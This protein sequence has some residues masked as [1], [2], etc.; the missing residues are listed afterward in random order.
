MARAS[1]NW[2]RYL[3]LMVCLFLL[4]WIYGY[5]DILPLRP[6]SIHQWRQADCLSL[7]DN[8]YKGK[9]GLFQPSLH[10]LFSDQETSGKSAG[11]FPLL[12][13]L[14][15]IL[16]K[17]FGKHE[18]IF[19]LVVMAFSF[20]GMIA[21]YK[22]C[23]AMLKD[24][25]WSLASV[26]FLFSSPIFA[27]YSNNFLVNVPAFSLMLI[28]LW[29]FYLF[30]MREQNRRL[31]YCM[32]LFV[33]VG[34]FKPSSLLAYAGLCLIYLA[35]ISGQIRFKPAGRVFSRP[36]QQLIP[37]LTVPL[38]VA[39][40][41]G[42]AVHYNRVHGGVYSINSVETYWSKTP[43]QVQNAMRILREFIVFQV[44]S[45]PSFIYLFFCICYLFIRRRKV[46][47]LW[48]LSIPV[49]LLG[50]LCFVLLFFYSLEYHDYYHI[51]FLIIPLLVNLAFLHYLR[52]REY[53][54]FSSLLLKLLFTFLLIYNVLYCAN[55]MRMRY[56]GTE[57]K[58]AYIR[59]LLSPNVDLAHWGYA[60]WAYENGPYESVTPV[61]RAHGIN[62]DDAVICPED[63]SYNITLYLMDQVGWTNAG[64][65]LVD[66][67]AVVDRIRHGAKY[68]ML[69]DTAN[70]KL[71][72]LRHF[73]AHPFFAYQKLHV[74]D[75][76]PYASELK[77][78][79]ADLQKK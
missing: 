47:H 1:H 44:L 26:I 39:A 25:F 54:L 53:Q 57:G 76:R 8:F 5:I 61:L 35:D 66:S 42:Y 40:W 37:F 72:F 75:L 33:L 21:L 71:P 79:P 59:Q 65:V 15:A 56:S 70:L 18:F 60:K 48:L 58:H 68:M 27:F 29:Q 51:D 73:G 31:W 3:F 14:V 16:W 9:G 38:L 13:Y 23:Y 30:W 19:R 36:L 12:Y 4:S 6:V 69:L 11:E 7:A 50:Y 62:P 45:I 43:E 32:A 67:A 34:L 77:G 10:L 78:R 46:A 63:P 74:Y 17:I 24:Y 20:S 41:Y 2:I 22:L 64:S 52:T 55:N 49:M 28:A